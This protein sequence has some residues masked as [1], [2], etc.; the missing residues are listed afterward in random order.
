MRTILKLAAIL[1]LLP[2][3]S[4]AKDLY[5]KSYVGDQITYTTKYED[6]FAK[7]ATN[8]NLGYI[9]MRAANPDV[10][11]W[12]PGDG[13]KVILPTRHILPDVEK[14]GIIINLPEMRLYA[15]LYEGQPP[16][17]YPIGI[18]REGLNTPT[19]ETSIVRKMANPEWRPTARMKK[20]DPSLPDVVPPGPDNPLGTHM[21]YLGWPTYG[22]HGTNKP[23][24]IGRRVSSGCIRLHLHNI[25][26]LF[27]YVKTGTRVEV[28]NQPIKL[29]WI[30]DKLYLEVHPTIE[31][32][33]QMEIGG[34]VETYDLRDEDLSLILK[35]AG[36]NAENLN[37]ELIRTAI[38]E[39]HGHPIEI[40]WKNTQIAAQKSDEEKSKN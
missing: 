12:L 40:G 11:P 28:I 32:A 25:R 13:T 26:E 21:L 17:T 6:T 14:N 30:E 20:E 38:K 35:A 36:D 33:D 24:G 18:G 9:E 19:G 7:I 2:Q 39:R 34:I 10:D 31:Q 8:Y 23:Y 4:L 16:I 3:T 15:F 1:A 5:D 37:W 22:I 27:Q 29:G